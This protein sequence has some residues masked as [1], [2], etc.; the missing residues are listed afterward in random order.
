MA[1]ETTQTAAQI[2]TATF[3]LW[4]IATT[5]ISGGAALFSVFAVPH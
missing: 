5:M 4:V 3:M 1:V 2:D